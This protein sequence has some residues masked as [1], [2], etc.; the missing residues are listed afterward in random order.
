M[1]REQGALSAELKTLNE[2]QTDT[3]RLGSQRIA[4]GV[5]KISRRT[6]SM[7]YP[8]D[9]LLPSV[10]YPFTI[11]KK[12]DSL[13]SVLIH[14][15]H[16]INMLYIFIKMNMINEISIVYWRNYFKRILLPWRNPML[17]K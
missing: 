3:G 2:Q 17:S 14:R 6:N 10:R 7:F 8:F 13:Y 12:K 9:L 15:F 1:A 4:N 11:P 16:V 5:Q